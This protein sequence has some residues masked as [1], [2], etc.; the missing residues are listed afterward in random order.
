[1]EFCSEYETRSMGISR[2]VV[3]LVLFFVTHSGAKPT[4]LAPPPPVVQVASVE[5]KDVP[6]YR[7]WIGTLTGQVNAD[8]KAQVT[9]YVLTQ[10]YKEGSYVRTGQLLFETD[11][12]PFQAALDQAKGQM[13]Q[14]EA[15][16]AARREDHGTTGE[17]GLWL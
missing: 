15:P 6:I 2:W 17:D 11:P 12:R 5:Q 14:A 4:A 13:A 8:S 9:G 3:P 10:N 7:E 1:M 16:S